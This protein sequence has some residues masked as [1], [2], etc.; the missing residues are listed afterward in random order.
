ML[1]AF[2]SSAAATTTV[3]ANVSSARVPLTFPMLECVGSGHGALTLRADYRAHLAAVQRDIGFAYIRGHGWLDDDMST[4]LSGAAN[5]FNW[6]SSIDFYLSVS[7]KPV[8]EL[9]FMPEALAS[10]TSEQRGA[11]SDVLWS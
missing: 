10:G 8:I 5:M 6:F 1:L 4:L 2:T 3:L 11:G 7:I 9:S